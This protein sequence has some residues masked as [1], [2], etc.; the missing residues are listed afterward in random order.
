MT[1]ENHQEQ[2]QQSRRWFTPEQVGVFLRA[3]RGHPFED[4]FAL[5]VTCGL[6]RGELFALRWT[7][8]HL[9]QQTLQVKRTMTLAP[10]RG[11]VVS[12]PKTR[13]SRR[14]LILSVCIAE[15]L[16][17]RPS[18]REAERE[19]LVFGAGPEAGALPPLL[20]SQQL[21]ALLEQAG[22]PLLRFA[23]LRLSAA[24]LLLYLDI[25]PQVVVAMLGVLDRSRLSP[26]STEALYAAHQR[27]AERIDARMRKAR[28]TP[29]VIGAGGTTDHG[30]R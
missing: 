9:E 19:D 4:C 10:G 25:S 1:V 16:Q 23:A 7:D 30:P 14:T 28:G 6:R 27:A 20:V 13:A 26:L 18:Y 29:G 5:A 2:K 12:P 15:L 3:L 22:L 11:Q 21:R 17:Q 24:A 8:V